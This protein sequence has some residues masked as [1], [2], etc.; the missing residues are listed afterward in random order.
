LNIVTEYPAWFIIL[1]IL[2]G[3]LYSAVLY[4]K[5]SSEEFKPLTAKLLAV[6][7]F[8]SVTLVAFLLLTPMLRSLFRNFEKP[9]VIIAQDHT[10]SVIIGG[11]SVYYTG[12]YPEQLTEMVDQLEQDYNV[13]T[14]S[15]GDMVSEGLDFSYTGKQTDI[16]TLFEDM[17]T[18]YANRNVGAMLLASDGLYNKG[19][20]PVYGSEKIRFPVY[21]LALGDTSVRKDVFLRRVNYN[22]IAFLGNM[23]PIEVVVGANMCEGESGVLTV[24]SGGA[25]LFSKTIRFASD[26]YSETV[27]VLLE[28]EES[29]MQ[30]FRINLRPVE[31]EISTVNN[32]RDVF[33]DILDNKQKILILY[34]S[35]HPDI[36]ALKYAIE[37]NQANEV[38]HEIYD[39]FTGN[40][41]EFNLLVL[42][43]LPA[44]NR[45]VTRLIRQAGEQELP[46]LY[47][48]GTQS[49]VP[50]FNAL[51]A[52]MQIQA[53]TEI[54]NESV[55]ALNTDFS[56]FTISESTRTA[57]EGF[58][59]LIAPFGEINTLVSANTL[60]Y[61]QIGS[62][63][64]GYPLV[65]FNETLNTR[66]GVIAGEGIWRWQMMNFQKQGNHNAFNE[67]FSKMVQY[68]SVKA[69]KNRFRITGKNDFLENEPVILDAEVYNESYELINDPEV[70]IT[71][72]NSR[73]DTYPFV[74]GKTANAYQLNA[75]ILP[76]DSYTYDA[77]VRVGNDLQNYRGEFTVSPLNIEALNIIADHNLLFRLAS[78]HDGQIIY[79]DQMAEFPEM[80]KARD[81]IRT[82]TYT[83]KRFSELVNIF[84]VFLLI[85]ALLSAEWFIRKRSGSY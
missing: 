78:G 4:Y 25:T 11:D 3:L 29:G 45:D 65:L 34:A 53:E 66:T 59:P 35:P 33:I 5:N 22:R 77:T 38:T 62:L 74:F 75:G 42:H 70:E 31:G 26:H 15:F 82:I 80:L 17:H 47:I 14:Y 2:L 7:R 73:G 64:T 61:Q 1:C 60:F 18:R 79:P 69:D 24:S 20:N 39:R 28:A 46:V 71:I 44:A 57:V 13:R 52:G 83:E 81:D 9:L 16:S 55:P 23:F 48:L 37:S 6:F 36:A 58:P 54:F 56:L 68:L 43:Q 8:V 40:V 32:T 84:W 63:V 30:R 72:R 50:R 41:S 10:E 76:V 67:L 19:I 12:S 27:Q 85:M 51:N 49:S 21:T